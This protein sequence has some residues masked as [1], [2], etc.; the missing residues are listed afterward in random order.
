MRP[1]YGRLE[2][3]DCKGRDPPLPVGGG[4]RTLQR[5]GH[6]RDIHVQMQVGE[7]MHVVK[8]DGTIWKS[9]LLSR[10]QPGLCAHQVTLRAGTSLLSVPADEA[11]SRTKLHASAR[12][13]RLD[14]ANCGEGLYRLTTPHFWGP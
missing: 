9:S 14:P 11:W 7:D 1:L 4:I 10:L 3:E 6:H 8:R 13:L 2:A 12:L 5:I